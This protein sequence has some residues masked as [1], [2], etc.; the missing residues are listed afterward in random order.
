VFVKVCG[1]RSARDA[2]L[3]AEA[4]ADAIGLN[5]WPGSPRYLPPVEAARLAA[6]LPATLLCVGVFV[7]PTHDEVVA[8]LDAGV[9]HVAQLHGDE[10]SAFVTALAAA[11]RRVWKAVRLDGEAALAALEDDA[12]ERFLVDAAGPGYGGSG[13]AAD[14]ALAARAAAR[15]PVLL[16]GGLDPHNVAAAIRAVRPFGVDVASGVERAPGEK[17]RAR[18]IAFVRAAKGAG[19]GP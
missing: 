2:L 1:V 16:A 3:C 13:R 17:D 10:P 19:E 12:P 11:G 14:L 8:L 18:V 4:G 5:L 6:A 9:I 7:N 15:R